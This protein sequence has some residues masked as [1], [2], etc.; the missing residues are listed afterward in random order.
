MPTSNPNS[1]DRLQAWCDWYRSVGERSVLGYIRTMNDTSESDLDILQDAMLTAYQCMERG[2]YVPH[3]SI[4][5]TAYVKGIV[6]NKIREVRKMKSVALVSLDEPVVES[7]VG[8]VDEQPETL[9]E[10]QEKW[11][12]LQAGLAQLSRCRRTVLEAY[13]RGKSTNQI[14]Q[15]LGMSEE[16]VRQHKSRGLRSLRAMAL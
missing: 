11:L 14:A 13:L 10:W 1:A 7:L 9:I 15:M 8:C 16:L 12:T 3:Q 6:R 2:S 5:L 4:P